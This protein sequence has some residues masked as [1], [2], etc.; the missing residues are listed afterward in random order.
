MGGGRR[1]GRKTSWRGVRP[2]LARGRRGPA[3]G[4]VLRAVEVAGV[5]V[6]R[7][8]DGLGRCSAGAGAGSQLAAWLGRDGTGARG[9]VGALGWEEGEER[10]NRGRGRGKHRADDGLGEGTGSV[11][12]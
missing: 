10:E 2:F 5:G 12:G 6:R 1:N 11:R 7:V 8:T 4:L 9:A 3:V